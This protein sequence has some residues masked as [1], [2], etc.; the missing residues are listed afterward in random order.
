MPVVLQ[1][2]AH[3][4]AAAGRSEAAAALPSGPEP[5]L[6]PGAAEPEERLSGGAEDGGPALQAL[7][8]AR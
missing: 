3:G 8:T 2:D 5:E 6:L 1:E 4:G 7:P